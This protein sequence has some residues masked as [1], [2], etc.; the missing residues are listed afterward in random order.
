MSLV[1][2]QLQRL[3]SCPNQIL[4][5]QDIARTLYF[6]LDVS[7]VANGSGLDLKPK[8]K[9]KLWVYELLGVS[10]WV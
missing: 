6:A 5:S 4:D 1:F 9:V 10:F 3:E 7:W 8:F 2:L